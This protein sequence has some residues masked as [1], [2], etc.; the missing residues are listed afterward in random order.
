MANVRESY[1]SFIVK[2][3]TKNCSDSYYRL[4]RRELKRDATV[5]RKVQKMISLGGGVLFSTT[6][7]IFTLVEIFFNY[8]R[9]VCHLRVILFLNVSN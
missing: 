8:K 2:S 7:N 5:C 6:E 9:L 1:D 3:L 4:K